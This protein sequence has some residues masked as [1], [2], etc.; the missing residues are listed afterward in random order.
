M[1][2]EY[3][4]VWRH[5]HGYKGQMAAGFEWPKGK[6]VILGSPMGYHRNPT[7]IP[8]KWT[9][10]GPY[11]AYHMDAVVDCRNNA[12]SAN[13]VCMINQIPVEETNDQEGSCELHSS[14][15]G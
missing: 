15:L 12:H 14:K 8:T 10:V 6:Q 9:D 1:T 13:V 4:I 7:M 3:R 2:A 11:R 5:G